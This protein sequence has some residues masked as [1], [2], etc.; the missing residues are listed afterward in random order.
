VYDRSYLTAE[1]FEYVEAL[2]IPY[3][4]NNDLPQQKEDYILEQTARISGVRSSQAS[5]I[6]L[7]LEY[8]SLSK[9]AG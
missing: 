7:Y 2:Y 5:R 3:A 6:L 8:D 4:L 1:D 9:I